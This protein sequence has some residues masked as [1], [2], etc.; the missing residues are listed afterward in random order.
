MRATIHM[1]QKTQG[2]KIKRRNVPL[3]PM[4]LEERIY[5]TPASINKRGDKK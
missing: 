5:V 2:I 4:K 1:I 3:S